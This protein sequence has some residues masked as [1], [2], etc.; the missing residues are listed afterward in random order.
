MVKSGVHWKVVGDAMGI[1]YSSL[2]HGPSSFRDG[3]EFFEDIK[4][5]AINYEKEYMVPD[6]YN[7]QLA[8]ETTRI[9]LANVPDVLRP[10]GRN[11]VTTLMDDRL[12]RAM[13]YNEPPA[14]YSGIVKVIFKSRKFI[15]ENFLPPRP[16]ALQVRKVTD[17]PDHKTGRYFMVEYSSEP[18]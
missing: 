12:R 13:L 4:E 7:H 11:I 1:D 17:E 2:R 5:W 14:I 10:Y 18:W 3:L 16:Y 6:K 8:E 15:L 9:L